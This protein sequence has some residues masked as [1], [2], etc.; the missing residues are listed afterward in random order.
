[1]QR[2][3]AVI[4]PTALVACLVAGMSGCG[5]SDIAP[6]LTGTA[7]LAA[8]GSAGPA[9]GAV[10]PS[11]VSPPAPA[12]AAAPEGPTVGIVLPDA[13]AG[14]R[15]GALERPILE[16]AFTEN[17]LAVDIR[18]AGG[19]SSRVPALAQELITNGVKVLVVA[20]AD[21]V[22]GAQANAV[23]RRAGVPVINLDHLGDR[24]GADFFVGP[25]PVASGQILGE[26]LLRCMRNEG[27]GFG[28]GLI[29]LANGPADDSLAVAMK[30]AYV[31][32]LTSAGYGV[33][34]SADVPGWSADAGTAL[35]ERVLTKSGGDLAGLL[36][37]SEDLAGAVTAVLARDARTLTVVGVGSSPA[38]LQ[39][40]LLGEQCMTLLTSP[41]AE[42]KAVASLA[43]AIVNADGGAIA[44]LATGTVTDMGSRTPVRS[45]LL[46]PQ[47]V[48]FAD[49]ATVV[50]AGLIPFSELC[51]TGLA[52]EA[53]GVAGISE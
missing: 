11:P 33:G 52:R 42:A 21:D 6:G 8:Q 53:C 26:G 7:S 39:R 4:L 9:D 35:L 47:P 20:T 50:E 34:I 1:M 25:D 44:G 10:A 41:V 46:Q 29:G 43:T 2:A 45:V 51:G 28:N 15:W 24:G 40:V 18:D 19:I 32:V 12:S 36:A 30:Q 38:A 16:R 17:G 49:L 37:G 22:A 27:N 5:S 23:A 14:H 31:P 48:F 3:G 13:L